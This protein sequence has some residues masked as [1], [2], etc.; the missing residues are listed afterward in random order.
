MGPLLQSPLGGPFSEV[1]LYYRSCL[2]LLEIHPLVTECRPV[3][4][5]HSISQKHWDI[6]ERPQSVLPSYLHRIGEAI[7]YRPGHI[8]YS[9][10]YLQQTSRFNPFSHFICVNP[11]QAPR[12]KRPLAEPAGYRPTPRPYPG[13]TFCV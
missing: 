12:V 8:V 7:Q 3:Q 11:L 6:S 10:N 2:S 13:L 5:A 9:Q 1:L 4:A